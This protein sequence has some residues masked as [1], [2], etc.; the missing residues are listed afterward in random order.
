MKR[1]YFFLILLSALILN[2][3]TERDEEL[4]LVFGKVSSIQITT[5]TTIFIQKDTIQPLQISAKYYDQDGNEIRF[6]RVVNLEYYINNDKTDVLSIS[7]T[8]KNQ[9]QIQIS[10]PNK[11]NVMSNPLEITVL[12][13]EELVKNIELVLDRQSRQFIMFQDT[14]DFVNY[15]KAYATDS[16]DNEYVIDLKNTDFDFFVDDQE[17]ET[18]LVEDFPNGDREVN[19]EIAGISSNSVPISV[20]D[21]RVD[22]AR[23]EL[24][25]SDE[26]RNTYAVAG[27]AKYD[28]IYRVFDDLDRQVPVDFDQ[29]RVGSKTFDRITDI[30]ITESG[31]LE[32]AIDVYG[33][34]SNSLFINS[35]EDLIFEDRVLP[36]I[37]HVIHD[38]DAIG[39]ED[40]PSY[41]AIQG[42]LTAMNAAFRNDFR[43]SQQ[44]SMNAVDTY[45]QFRMATVDP[46]GNTLD[47]AGVIRKQISTD[48]LSTFGG[49][50]FNILFNDMW[51]PTKYINIFICN[52]DQ[53]I[54]YAYF[55][56][57]FEEQ[58]EGVPSTF[59]PNFALN[60]PYAIMLNNTHFDTHILSHEMGHY[61]ALPHTF[62]PGSVNATCF[63]SDFVN[64]TQDYINI[65][66]NVDDNYRRDCDGKR[67]YSTNFMDYNNG[68]KNS[69]TFDQRYRMRVTYDHALFF[70]REDLQGGRRIRQPFIKGEPDYSIKPIAC[71][72]HDHN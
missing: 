14:M 70:P 7:R 20:F 28:F 69:F 42:E 45:L 30:R 52:V 10:I 49:E 58:L 33:V 37:F 62:V 3:C 36:V 18:R 60:Y 17:I 29:L 66:S 25:F 53:S 51:D 6:D 2:S 11:R 46:L 27:R 26:T 9:Y 54:S 34:T 19:I 16:L 55:P 12:P 21:P 41:A 1:T 35:R 8:N 64:D 38:G 50:I 68:S 39:T 71:R 63:N 44:K 56:T 59:N 15:L 47:E 48:V 43:P 5:E 24:D 23:V 4:S 72:F 61:L 22:I 31:L 67:F 13:L 57:L 32:A 40:N 65:F